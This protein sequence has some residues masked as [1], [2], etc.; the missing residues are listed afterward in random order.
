MCVFVLNLNENLRKNEHLRGKWG[1]S[2][3][4]VCNEHCYRKYFCLVC[5]APE[6]LYKKVVF[7]TRS[8]RKLLHV[9]FTE[10]IYV[11]YFL[12]V[13]LLLFQARERCI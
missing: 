5:I 12:Y 11:Y 8:I 3:N 7:K 10:Y 4:Y 6:K 9:I 1:Y 13:F 2:G